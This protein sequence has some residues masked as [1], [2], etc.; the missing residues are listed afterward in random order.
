MSSRTALSVAWR[1]RIVQYER[2]FGQAG[3]TDQGE[4]PSRRGRVP[5][6]D[7][8]AV[9]AEARTEVET[10]L[11]EGTLTRSLEDSSKEDPA[12]PPGRD[13]SER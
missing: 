8:T 12:H 6:E 9:G 4:S 1:G 5:L 7:D 2:P 10:N 3:M 11:C 13:M